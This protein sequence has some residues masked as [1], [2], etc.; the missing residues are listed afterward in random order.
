MS[1][2]DEDV[3]QHPDG[4]TRLEEEEE[5]REVSDENIEK[6]AKDYAEYLVVNS[7][8]E[9]AQLDE[10]IQS[11]HFR[12]E[13]FERQLE[14]MH[15]NVTS[16]SEKVSELHSH[17][18]KLNDLFNKIDQIET[19]VNVVNSSVEALE[20]SINKAEKDLEPSKLRK[21]MSVIPG[22]RKAQPKES[23][24]TW[25]PPQL[26]NSKDYFTPRLRSLEETETPS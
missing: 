9:K 8:Q 13:E 23:T 1:T 18:L 11:I 6:S 26:F 17:T 22:M 12:V 5:T 20:Q 21:V 3:E 15:Q 7:K 25:Q 10:R 4:S 16:T 2:K 19:F 24:E 14:W